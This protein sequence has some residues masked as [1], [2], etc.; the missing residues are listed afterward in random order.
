MHFFLDQAKAAERQGD[1]LSARMSYMKCVEDL[2][3]SGA[4]EADI[5]SAMK[6]YEAFT[7]RDPIF[8]KLIARLLPIIK[9]N[10]GILQSDISKQFL[11]MEWPELYS[12]TR[13]VSREDISYA[14]YFADKQGLILRAKKGRSYE[15]R[16]IKDI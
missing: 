4:S 14:L 5:Q 6:E 7:K 8:A 2:K 16:I 12:Y 3:R 1:W 15:L 11:S 9:A 10:P 13:E